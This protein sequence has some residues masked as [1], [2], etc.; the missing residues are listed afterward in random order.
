MAIY[1]ANEKVKD[2]YIANEKVESG[3]LGGE[4]VY[5]GDDLTT[6]IIWSVHSSVHPGFGFTDVA[7]GNGIFVAGRGQMVC[8]SYD[9][10][11]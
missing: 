3:F 5:R 10:I 1:L 4:M 7:F 11:D 2:L 8:A 9:G 6:G